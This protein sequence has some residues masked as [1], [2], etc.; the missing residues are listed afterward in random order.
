MIKGLRTCGLGTIILSSA[1]GGGQA[2][3]V[4]PPPLHITATPPKPTPTRARWVFE[5]P[6]SGLHAKIDL[7]DGRAVYAGNN[8][9]REMEKTG[10]PLVDAPTL[11]LGDL[12]GIR[13]TPDGQYAF[14]A[15]DGAVYVAKDPMGS[16][17]TVRPSPLADG[18]TFIDHDP[19]KSAFVGVTAEGKVMRTTD[20]GVTWKDVDYAGATKPYG[21]AAEIGMDSKGNGILLV[22]PQR[23]YVTHDDGATWAPIAALHG[24]GARWVYHDGADRVFVTGY[25][26]QS[27][28][29]NGNA[30][31]PTTDKAAPIYKAPEKPEADE[32]AQDEHGET[33]SVLVGDHVVEF[34]EITRRGK[35][36]EIKIGSAAL[37][38]KIEKPA[39]NTELVGENGVSKHIAAHGHDLIYLRDDDDA[40]ENAPTTTLYRSKDFGAT[41]T[42][43]S[44]LQGVEAAY[45]DGV[46]VAAGPKGFVYVTPLCAKDERSGPTCG[47]RQVRM[48]G[49]QFEDMSFTEEFEPKQF[50]FDEAHDKVFVLGTHEGRQHVYESP[51]SQNK[52]SRTKLLDAGTYSKATI[53][54][55]AKGTPRAF[56]YDYSKGWVV[57]KLGDDGKEA[58]VQ[59]LALD[60]GNIAFIGQRGLVFAGHDKGWETIDAGDNW[61]R[62]ATNGYAQ[63]LV[64]SEA[65]CINGDAQRVG[66]DLPALTTGDKIALQAEPNKPP[67]VVTPPHPPAPPPQDITCKVSGSPSPITQTPSSD[68]VDGIAADRWATV[69]HDTD[70]K[71]GIVVGTKNAVRELPLF[72]ALP[73]PPAKP[74]ANPEDLRSGERVLNDGVVAARYRFA[75]RNGG[76]SYNPVDVELAWWSAVTGRTQHHTL[77]KVNAFRVSRYGFSGTPQI[78]DGGLLFQGG[79]SDPAY[80]I[81]DDG[82]V[83]TITLPK[84]AGVSEAERLSKRW[85][86]ADSA[87]GMV[88]IS[89]SDDNAKTWNQTAWGLGWGTLGLM[90]IADKA[91]VSFGSGGAHTLLFPVD[92]ALPDDPPAPVVIDDSTVTTT[93]DAK[94]G[95]HRFSSYISSD[96]RPIRVKIDNVKGTDKWTTSMMPSNRVMHDAPGGKMCTSAYVLSGYDHSES[97]TMFVYPDAGGTWTGWRF[98]RPDDRNKSG[99]IAEPLTCK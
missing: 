94:A 57:H 59:Y 3:V 43:E 80:F 12:T 38:D 31:T 24:I 11:A 30:L 87:G 65:G 61:T 53:A 7:G 95:R 46:D 85:L 76:G 41:W 69:K 98:R 14:F 5:H 22:L 88:Q 96:A 6:E 10:D 67:Q 92:A 70:G 97:I 72:G 21:K 36:R 71:I 89:A 40:D 64:C 17:D 82:K 68:M 13:K 1:C 4:T 15:T 37:G 29:L 49:G 35:V 26:G 34:V 81:H 99:M 90:S 74:P 66:W 58:P 62:V 73:K 78:V 84:G 44:Q 83:D 9:R 91:T 47:R 63:S 16:F 79:T 86:L 28:V 42:K 51:L 39:A 2:E 23:L 93:C 56:E 55:D 32:T 77:P 27:A 18:K 60:R 50:V 33:K 54:V 20:F 25:G 8:G 19:G 75:P 48:P 52:F 45:G